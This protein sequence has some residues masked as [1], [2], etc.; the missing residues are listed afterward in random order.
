MVRLR[1][2]IIRLTNPS[3]YQ[4]G[5]NPCYV[6]AIIQYGKKPTDEFVANILIYCGLL[7]F[8]EYAE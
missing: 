6:I 8:V 2:S 5:F 3:S 7:G 1:F 4:Q